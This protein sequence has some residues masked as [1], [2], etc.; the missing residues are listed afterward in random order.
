[1]VTVVIPVYNVEEYIGECLNSVITQTYKDL[2]ILCIDDCGV[3]NSISIVKEF[4]KIDGR[5]KIINHNV[6]RGLGGSRNTGIREAKGDYITFIDS[7]DV[8][9][10]KMI[11][12]LLN[13]IIEKDVDVAVCGIRRFK[14]ND[15]L[16][17]ESTF[18]HASNVKSRIINVKNNE[19]RLVDVWPSAC[20]K[21]FKTSIIKKYNLTFP[22]KMLYEDHYFYYNYFT[23]IDKFY[24]NDKYFYN[25]RG[26]REGSITTTSVGR[27]N[28]IFKVLAMLMPVFKENFG[29]DWEKNYAKICFRLLW[30][31]QFV[32]YDMQIWLTYCEK[33]RNKLLEL[34]DLDLIRNSI[35][36]HIS[37]DD[38]FFKY[39]FYTGIKRKLYI[40]KRKLKN[41]KFAIKIYNVYNRIRHHKSRRVL[42]KELVWGVYKTREEL[43]GLTSTVEN[44]E[45]KL[46]SLENENTI[47]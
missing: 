8:I 10:P 37:S 15:V 30:E 43:L 9:E 33:A 46:L 36:S 22:E 20:N 18:H 39:V 4:M 25:Y 19:G 32:L 29:D 24:Y 6:N 26:A 47:L 44:M 14:D 16:S 2:E 12:E 34:F 27:E 21:L 38:P 42:M 1:M 3:D 7:D 17:L 5:I 35:D 11:E 23:K 13:N 41:N 45:S 31:R 28:E 40:I